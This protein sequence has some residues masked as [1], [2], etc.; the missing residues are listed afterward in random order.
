MS[1]KFNMTRDINGYN[2][3]GLDFTDS[4]YSVSLTANADTTLTV[5]AID[6]TGGASYSASAKP[7]L[8]AVFEYTP[9]TEVWIAK[10]ASA[11]IPGGS[12]FAAT[13]SQMLPA[14]RKVQGGDILHFYTSGTGVNV[15][16]SFYWINQ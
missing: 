2:G 11:S 5:P 3:F 9:G 15:S 16:V 13:S 7:Q 8:I 4:A 10:N 6:S 12:S 1:T 14:A